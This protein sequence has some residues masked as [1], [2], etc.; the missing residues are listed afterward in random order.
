MILFKQVADLQAAL[1]TARHEGKTIGFVPT[2]GA[3][4]EGHLSL[5]ELARH[6]YDITVCSIFVNPTQ[7]NDPKDFEKYPVTTDAD[8]R[9]LEQAG[10]NM[11][12]LP[13]VSEIYPSGT[14]PGH[15]YDLGELE[16]LLDGAYRPGHF[17]GV[18]QVVH[19]LLD[20]VQPNALFLGQKD[21]QQCLV[22]K[23]M[24]QLENIPVEIIM[25]PTRREKDGLALSSRNMR[26][27]PEARE[28]ATALYKALQYFGENITVKSIQELRLE[29]SAF[30]LRNDFEKVDYIEVADAGSLLPVEEITP[31]L[32]LVLL[33]AAFIEGV[34]LIDN[35]EW[36]VAG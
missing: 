35:L 1:S 9:L 16:G 29:S 19:R 12:F 2:M 31:G 4:H 24:V 10:I 3:L 8:I 25:A 17:Q 21:Y 22:L 13:G 23:R 5:L 11:L 6:Q 27:S 28:K 20:I 33:T 36:T 14:T 15:H 34:R 18:C 30:L 32:K 26:L 7:F